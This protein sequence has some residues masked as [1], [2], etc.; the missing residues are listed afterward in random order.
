MAE[1]GLEGAYPFVDEEQL[2]P[3]EVADAVRVGCPALRPPDRQVL[4]DV[5]L[6]RQ[7]GRVI[8]V[9]GDQGG[10]EYRWSSQG[11]RDL[12]PIARSVPVVQHGYRADEPTS[13]DVL[14][15]PVGRHSHPG[16]ARVFA[17]RQVKP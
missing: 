3:V 6:D 17:L 2:V 14:L 15:V 12:D 16:L 5:E 1:L 13:A 8:A 4:V 10:R 9:G 11:R 7:A